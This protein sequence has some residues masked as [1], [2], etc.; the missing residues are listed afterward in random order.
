MKLGILQGR[1]SRPVNGLIQ[2]FPFD[3]WE[4]EFDW[5]DYLKLEHMEWIIN[6]NYFRSNPFFY[7][8]LRDFPISS[9]GL[10]NITGSSIQAIRRILN[11]TIPMVQA[12]EIDRITFPILEESNV[13]DDDKRK[14]MKEVLEDYW[15]AD[16]GV[17]LSLETD[18]TIEHL[19][20]LLSVGHMTVTYDTGNIQMAGIDHVDFINTF[21]KHID[22]V[23]IKDKDIITGKNVTLG[24][25]AWHT[26]FQEIF[27]TLGKYNYDGLWTLQTGRGQ[28]GMEVGRSLQDIEIVE[29]LHEQFI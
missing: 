16:A 2:E 17:T 1:L 20:D 28:D 10:D 23:H 3:T 5:L 6:K 15:D 21:H 22:N 11:L 8:N 18:C 4:S 7:C 9:V 12:Q 27:E 25:M 26:P 24:E 19:E 14:E 13:D 29:K